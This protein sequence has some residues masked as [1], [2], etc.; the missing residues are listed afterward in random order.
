MLQSFSIQV[1]AGQQGG[2]SEEQG[3][4]GVPTLIKTLPTVLAASS[5]MRYNTSLYTTLVTG[6]RGHCPRVPAGRGREGS[7]NSGW[8]PNTGSPGSSSQFRS[9]IL[10]SCNIVRRMGNGSSSWTQEMFVPKLPKTRR[11]GRQ[12]SFLS[13]LALWHSPP[14]WIKCSRKRRP[15]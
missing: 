8:R 12:Q 11:L 14:S 10:L 5:T 7:G 15:R 4:A 3:R 2:G 13:C 1:S 9:P 6:V